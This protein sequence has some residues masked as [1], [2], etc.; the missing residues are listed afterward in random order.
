MLLLEDLGHDT[1][2]DL[3]ALLAIG[4]DLAELV[5]HDLPGR[6]MA[7]GPLAPSPT[8]RCQTPGGFWRGIVPGRGTI[9]RQNDRARVGTAAG[10]HRGTDEFFRDLTL[11][12]S[13]QPNK[14]WTSWT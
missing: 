1:G 8:D 2:I 14:E 11:N 10:H 12:V 9:P 5:G 13:P 4:D 6:V 3:A 7:A